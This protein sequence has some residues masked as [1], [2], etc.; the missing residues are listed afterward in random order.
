M[1]I[2]KFKEFLYTSGTSLFCF[3]AWI[4]QFSDLEGFTGK[5]LYRWDAQ[6]AA[7][8]SSL[9]FPTIYN[10]FIFNLLFQVIRPNIQSISGNKCR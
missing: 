3:A 2:I 9:D 8:V 10:N 1:N 4:A 7:A 5:M 6:I